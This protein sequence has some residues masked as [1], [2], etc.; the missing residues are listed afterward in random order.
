ELATAGVFQTAVLRENKAV[1]V[2][3]GAEN[4]D[5]A[6]AQD[7]VTAYLGPDN[8]NHPFRVLEA[9]VLRIRRPE[10][11]CTLES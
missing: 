6:I 7:M 3:T 11:I 10:A 5:I 2:S 9:L 1:V 8:M 4:L